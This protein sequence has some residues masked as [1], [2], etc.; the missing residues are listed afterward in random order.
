MC[1]MRIGGLASGMDIDQIVKDLMKVERMPL[2]KLK[3]EKQTL[4]WQRDDYRS[5]N[6]LLLNFRSE[7][8]QMKLTTKYRARTTSSTNESYVTATASSAASQSSYSISKVTQLATTERMLNGGKLTLDAGNSLY[9]QTKGSPDITW[10]AGSIESK[11]ISAD[12]TKSV[13]SLD[14]PVENLKDFS[15]WSIKVNGRGYRVVDEDSFNAST[16]DKNVV[17]IDDTTGEI[18]FKENIA[19]DSSIRIDY[20]ADKKTDILSLSHHTS[21]LQ[22]SK[23]SIRDVFN[24]EG[25]EGQIKLLKSIKEG[26]GEP[27]E[28]EVFFDLDAEGNILDSE[29]TVIG[30]LDKST[31]KITFTL[32]NEELQEKGYLPPEEPEEGKTYNYK[33]EITYN[34]NYT[35]FAVDT[36]TSDGDMHESFLVAGNDTINSLASRINASKTGATLFY[37]EISGK[38]SL[39]RTETG[40]FNTENDGEDISVKGDLFN[41]IFKFADGT[42]DLGKNAKFTING[43]ETHRSANT[44]TMNG[45]TFTLKQ[46]F[47]AD[48][49]N[50][51][52]PPVSI[53]VNNDSTKVF[54]NIV[55][56]VNKYNELIEKISEK[57][58]EEVYRSYQPLTDAE[59]EELT[60]KQQEQW[61]EKARSG[62]LRR[63][64]ILTSVL[65]DMRNDFYQHVENDD[66]SSLYNQLSELGI[67]TSSSYLEGGKLIINEAKLKEAIENDPISV[68]NFF[69]SDGTTEGQKGV[70][71]RLYDSVTTAMDKLRDKAGGSLSANQTFTIGRQLDSLDDGIDRFEDRLVQIEDRYWRQFTA[72][73][74]AIQQANSQMNYLWQQ[75]SGA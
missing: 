38:M 68:E 41:N 3:Q 53:N 21:S 6:T 22:L 33:L 5:M 69:R 71:S 25:T 32:S 42:T 63:D 1:S 66:V 2:D 73:E 51:N 37:D 24:V 61:E 47:G 74:K 10:N 52:V 44:F 34:Q 26:D 18:H 35:N 8:T 7:L 17:W 43:I 54:D 12:G 30:T 14:V 49:D 57:T 56:F 58:Q 16:E 65:S 67:T 70:V 50:P 60:D 11:T 45:V 48:T 36:V 75:F 4:E 72:M 59:R 40:K 15:S 19:K 46:V 27:S 13:F 20:I 28:S 64:S 39:S 23:K 62:L 9:E 55:E 31:G 29:E